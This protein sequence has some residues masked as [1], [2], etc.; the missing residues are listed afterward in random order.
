MQC[1]ICEKNQSNV[2]CRVCGQTK[3]CKNCSKFWVYQSKL[4][5]SYDKQLAS[6]YNAY[7]LFMLPICKKCRK[8]HINK[9]YEGYTQ[10]RIETI[11]CSRCYDAEFTI[12]RRTKVF[13][14]V[15]IGVVAVSIIVYFIID[16]LVDN[17]FFNF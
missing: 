13:G 2:P 17:K 14:W 7:K 8:I 12:T 15:I 3:F 16:I 4:I 6:K 9:E 10:K 11:Y 5:S 1:T